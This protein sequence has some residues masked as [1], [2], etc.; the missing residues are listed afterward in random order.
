MIRLESSSS[1]PA[2]EHAPRAFQAAARPLSLPPLANAPALPHAITGATSAPL[3]DNGGDSKAHLFYGGHAGLRRVGTDAATS[4]ILDLN[5][6][7]S[8][9]T[10]GR[11]EE[12]DDSGKHESSP[13]IGGSGSGDPKPPTDVGDAWASGLRPHAALGQFTHMIGDIPFAEPN[14]VNLLLFVCVWTCT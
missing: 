14:G 3:G 7:A 11:G 4:F 8:C 10:G 2:A 9:A 6:D 1:A 5:R 13:L 12:E